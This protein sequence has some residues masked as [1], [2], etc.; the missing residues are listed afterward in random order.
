VRIT[1]RGR[2][3]AG[4]LFE[5]TSDSI[6]LDQ[7]GRQLLEIFSRSLAP[8][9]AMPSDSGI[10][11]QRQFDLL[12]KR[13][14]S[15]FEIGD[16]A[17]AAALR[18]TALL[19][20]PEADSQR[21]QLIDEYARRNQ[22]LFERSPW[23]PHIGEKPRYDDPVWNVVLE[24]IVTNWKRS[25]V[26]CEYLIRNRRISREQATTLAGNTID[27]ILSM[28]QVYG[29]PLDSCNSTKWDFIRDVATK[30][31]TLTPQPRAAAFEVSGQVVAAA[32]VFDA[33]LKMVE[34]KPF[35]AEDLKFLED[36]ILTRVPEI[37]TGVAKVRTEIEEYRRAVS[38]ASSSTRTTPPRP[39]RGASSTDR[40]HRVIRSSGVA[41]G[42]WNRTAVRRS[43]SLR[44]VFRRPKRR[45]RFCT[46]GPLPDEGEGQ[47]QTDPSYGGAILQFLRSLF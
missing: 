33:A 43:D 26:H 41:G 34:G 17:R 29:H 30:I 45:P 24:E 47:T 44:R 11:P 18:E 13:A 35:S 46:Q 22:N 38:D 42:G 27:S 4:S 2:R 1:L 19:I 10:D 12:S 3:A 5:K 39:A 25:L 15:F 9:T 37:R 14:D 7:G 20:R 21:I 31:P 40:G 16:F 28:R 6:P 36:L 8:L 23:P 32:V